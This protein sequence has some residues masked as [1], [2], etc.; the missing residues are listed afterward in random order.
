[1]SENE[2]NNYWAYE[3]GPLVT[4][5]LLRCGIIKYV[6]VCKSQNALLPPAQNEPRALTIPVPHHI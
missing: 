6:Q 4:E 1:M 3:H 2:F 5:W